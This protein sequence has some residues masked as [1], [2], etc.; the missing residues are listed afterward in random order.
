MRLADPQA[1][2]IALDVATGAGHTALALAPSVKC[3]VAAD[4]AED[5]LVQV[6]LIAKERGLANVMPRL[7]DVEA[8][9][10]DDASFDLVTCRIAP[11]HFLDFALAIAEMARVL[12]SGGRLVIEDSC[13]PVDPAL[14]GFIDH[15]ERL[16]D[17]THVH[18]S[19]EQ[20]WLDVLANVGLSVLHT[21]VYR[22][23]RAIEPWMGRSGLDDDGKAA[24]RS[25]FL[26]A[27]LGAVEHFDITYDDSGH[28]A[29]YTDDKLILLAEK[30]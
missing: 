21:E 6:R 3:V 25:A 16:R 22:K 14:A 13:S 30:A 17:P 29:T 10:F 18:S 5:M 1:E 2:T 19:S 9:P 24:V 12:R 11:H 7:C 26:E 4:L 20:E 23:R 27:P 15:V 8:M 28:P